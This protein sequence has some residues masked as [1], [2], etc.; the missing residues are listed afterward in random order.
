MLE[1]H[2]YDCDQ[3]SSHDGGER[4]HGHPADVAE[5]AGEGA[6]EG[7]DEAEHTV[8]DGAGGMRGDGVEHDGEG[9]DVGGHDEEEEDDLGEAEELAAERAKEDHAGVGQVV[10]V[11]VAGLELADY[12]PGVGGEDAEDQDEEEA[13]G[14]GLAGWKM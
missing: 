9:K 11:W 14:E 2:C 4:H 3:D 6:E 8:D 13:A 1:R 5:T 10:D 7:E 12:V